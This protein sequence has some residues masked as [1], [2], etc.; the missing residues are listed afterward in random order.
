[1]GQNI[2]LKSHSNLQNALKTPEYSAKLGQISITAYFPIMQWED[3]WT[4]VQVILTI[5]YVLVMGK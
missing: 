5:E 3:D 2:W 4:L 1:M